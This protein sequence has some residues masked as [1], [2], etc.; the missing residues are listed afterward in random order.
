M[1]EVQ[2]EA[3]ECEQAVVIV[4]IGASAGGLEAFKVLL[5]NLS[6]HTGLSFII[7]QHLATS[8]KSMLPDI[9][10]RFTKLPVQ[11][12]SDGTQPKPDPTLFMLFPQDPL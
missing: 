8:Q 6:P 5:E 2:I 7:I 9:L 12:V 4:G 1:D 10:S 11:E 3:K